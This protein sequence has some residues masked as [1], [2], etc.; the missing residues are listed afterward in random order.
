MTRDLGIQTQTTHRACVC[1]CVAVVVLVVAV[2]CA[3]RGACVLAGTAEATRQPARNRYAA[4]RPCRELSKNALGW[5]LV[6]QPALALELLV[7]ALHVA[8]QQGPLVPFL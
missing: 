8:R 7:G 6:R 3:V 5:G 4:H 1:V 2:V